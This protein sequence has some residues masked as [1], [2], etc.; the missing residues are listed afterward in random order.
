MWAFYDN[1][2]FYLVFNETPIFVF[3]FLNMFEVNLSYRKKFLALIALTQLVQYRLLC[4]GG[5]NSGKRR[6]NSQ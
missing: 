3:G 5:A 6:W 1:S 2:S 4:V